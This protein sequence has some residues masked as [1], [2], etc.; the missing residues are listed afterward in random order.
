MSIFFRPTHRSFYLYDIV[1]RAPS[2]MAHWGPIMKVLGMI[3]QPGGM[4]V[5]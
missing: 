2:N 5:L 1:N 4:L 3:E